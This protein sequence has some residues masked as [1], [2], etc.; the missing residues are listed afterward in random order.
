M[1]SAF[2]TDMATVLQ[3]QF[4]QFGEAVSYQVSESAAVALTGKV[5]RMATEEDYRGDKP[6]Q[7]ETLELTIAKDAAAV[8]GG[9]ASP[10][11]DAKVTVRGNTYAV[12]RMLEQTPYSVTFRCVR[13]LQ[14]EGRAMRPE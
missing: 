13:K 10:R 7:I 3:L 11:T 1:P 14:K 6:V 9:I 4:E 12:E 8:S 2:D 5:G